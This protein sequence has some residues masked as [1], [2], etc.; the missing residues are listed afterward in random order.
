M[1]LLEISV[2][3]W[4][5][6]FG[7][8]TIQLDV[9]SSAPVVVFHG[10]NMRGKTS[11]LRAIIWCLYGEIREQNG[12]TRLD[13][14]RMANLDAVQSGEADFGVSLKF[15]H[16]GAYYGLHRR[17]QAIEQQPGRVL[18]TRISVD[19][20]PTGGHPFP[21][22]QIPE[23]IDSILSRD[24]ADFFFFDGEMLNRFE[25][26]LRDERAAA[27][28]FVR[29]QVERALGLPFMSNLESDLDSIQTSITTNMNQALR[30]A[31]RHT[32]LTEQYQSKKDS[33][34]GTER[35]ITELR[36]HDEELASQI[37]EL[38]SQLAKV[39]EIKD[40]YF[41][42]KSLESQ[43]AGIEDTIADYRSQLAGLAE[44]SWW[45]P[46]ADLLVEDLRSAE[47]AID[48][49]ESTNR[50]RLRLE[51]RIGH[52]E[53]ELGTGVCP[54][55][56]QPVVNDR[57]PHIR[58]DLLE[59][60]REL[61]QFPSA[62]LD[63][64]RGRRDKL[65]RFGSGA[66]LLHRVHEQEQD[67]RRERMRRDKAN[68]RIRQISEQLSG[69]TVDIQSLER[70]LVDRKATKQRSGSALLQLE[71]QRANIKAE[72][73]KLG[74]QIA[75]QP[76]I[77]SSERRLQ[78]SVKEALGI[79]NESFGQFRTVMK[80]RVEQSTSELF[81][82]LTTEKDYSGVSISDDYLLSVVDHQ[83]RALGMISAGANQILTTAFIGALGEC[84]VDEAPMVMD[85]PFGR[86][87]TGHRAAILRWV[88]TF[89]TQ[90]ILFVQSGE[91][92]AERDAAL[93]GGKIGREYTIERLSPTRSEVR[94][95]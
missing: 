25:E 29:A 92:N 63:D 26:R 18:V 62:N 39:D 64:A 10:E 44:D 57:E 51:M 53:E 9:D 50:E 3:N 68:Q 79:V 43:V 11:L 72:V 5:P 12:R 52:L 21:S 38:E 80:E 83:D 13:V 49:A 59:R 42:R 24:I 78:E 94:S 32:S 2:L 65:R 58:A 14:A 33:L 37:G 90:V 67:L 61:A 7:T 74:S 28:G 82:R 86:L 16:D 85:T 45:L 76:E 91:Y 54:T 27:Q 4:G 1:Q 41:E 46:V 88:S 69:N 84:S 87:D 19:L 30:R 60:Q 8:H 17:G 20:I 48:A 95:A 75:Q 93:L 71:Q 55:C 34:E 77:D 15:S 56:G 81:R 66:N 40:L 23:V 31:S 70:N 47:K 89:D 73:N 6:F 35:N 22:A 36:A